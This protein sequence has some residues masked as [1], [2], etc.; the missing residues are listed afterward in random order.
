MLY[1]VRT[2]LSE[3]IDVSKS[4]NSKECAICH[5]WYLKHGFKFQKSFCNGCHDLPC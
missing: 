1:Y 4:N 3:R 2:Y 5:N